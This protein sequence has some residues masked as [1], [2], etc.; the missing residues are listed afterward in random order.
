MVPRLRWT[1]R[2]AIR[3]IRSNPV[4]RAPYVKKYGKEKKSR[5]TN[6]NEVNWVDLCKLWSS[7]FQY[8]LC[9]DVESVSGNI[10]SSHTAGVTSS[11][12]WTD[13]LGF[14]WTRRCYKQIVTKQYQKCLTK[15]TGSS[16][17]RHVWSFRRLAGAAVHHKWLFKL[18][19]WE[20]LTVR[21]CLVKPLF[22]V[23][24]IYRGVFIT[25][26]R[27]YSSYVC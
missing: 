4:K 26:G 17:L 27:L 12:H 7:E 5:K 15:A 25:T 8:I 19:I 14:P 21:T 20:Q 10:R 9:C 6:T 11:S 24:L 23:S 22:L 3:G 18:W 13:I 2:P 16:A 1:T